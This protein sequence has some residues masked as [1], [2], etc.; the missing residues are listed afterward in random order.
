MTTEEGE[1][2]A[3]IDW[4]YD[5]KRI[6]QKG[7]ATCF[8]HFFVLVPIQQDAKRITQKGM[9]TAPQLNKLSFEVP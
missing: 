3:V 7:M 5:A 9:A 6:T 4:L 8:Q 1:S 2:E